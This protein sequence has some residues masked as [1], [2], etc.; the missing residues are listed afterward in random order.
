MHCPSLPRLIRACRPAIRRGPVA[1]V[2]VQDGI[3]V[4]ETAAWRS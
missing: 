3:A 4:A 1:V 2:L